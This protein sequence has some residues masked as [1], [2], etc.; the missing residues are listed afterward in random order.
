[1]HGTI[2]ARRAR[3]WASSSAVS[4]CWAGNI[5]WAGD[6]FAQA[7]AS[8]PATPSPAAAAVASEPRL[9][10][11]PTTPVL[12]AGAPP[13]AGSAAI[14]AGAGPATTSSQSSPGFEAGLRLGIGLPLGN[15][16]KSALGQ[17]RKV[18]DLV[19]WRTPI[20]VDVAYRVSP[21]AS[22]GIYAQFGVGGTGDACTGKCD[23]SDLRIGAQ[24]QWRLDPGADVDP[25]LGLGV[26]YESLGFQTFEVPQDDMGD[27]LPTRT[28]ERLGGP[29]L[30]LQGGL[31]LRVED[32]LQL[33]PFVAASLG[34]YIGDSYRCDYFGPTGA[35]PGGSSI[36]GS[37][38]HAWLGVGVS[39]RYSP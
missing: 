39:G 9:S 14:D 32:A 25:W 11:A 17:Q 12:D 7:P 16:G 20:W 28:K 37:A 4:L 19:T 5:F 21:G 38:F 31:E 15:A 24:G 6:V 30:L 35:C 2:S 26:G 10:E 8:A 18:G 23:W 36:Q 33:G 22:Y 3:F 34:S 29:E 1:M 13:V 27:F